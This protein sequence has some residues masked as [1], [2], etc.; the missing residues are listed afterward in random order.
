MQA[1]ASTWNALFDKYTKEQDFDILVY[2]AY[3][4]D[5]D[6][7][8]N[9]LNILLRNDTLTLDDEEFYTVYYSILDQHADNEFVLDYIL[10]N[11]DKM[12][13]R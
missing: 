5:P 12:I 13:S 7:I 11:M 2:L 4:E 6:I 1:N 3:C 10:A 9:Y 8:V